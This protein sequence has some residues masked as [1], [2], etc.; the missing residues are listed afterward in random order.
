MASFFD[1]LMEMDTKFAQEQLDNIEQSVDKVNLDAKKDPNL[2]VKAAVL[3]AIP[4]QIKGLKTWLEQ[5]KKLGNVSN[6]KLGDG[7]GTQTSLKKG[8]ESPATPA[9]SNV[10]N[11]TPA[12]QSAKAVA[13]T[14]P[15]VKPTM[16]GQ[17]LKPPTA[18]KPLADIL[19]TRK[20]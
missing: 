20:I 6:D 9:L 7:I 1:I 8:E 12:Q 11:P 10:L 17:T 16:P 3:N 4:P 5:Q 18:A 15:A 14:T 13:P 19:K 2:A